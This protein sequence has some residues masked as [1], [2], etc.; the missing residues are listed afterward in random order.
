MKVYLE[1]SAG[2]FFGTGIVF[3]SFKSTSQF[4]ERNNLRM[5]HKI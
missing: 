1:S 4:Y 3:L 2:T 5:G